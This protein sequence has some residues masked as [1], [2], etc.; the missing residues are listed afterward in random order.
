MSIENLVHAGP[1]NVLS[2]VEKNLR[3]DHVIEN[4]KRQRLD[5]GLSKSWPEEDMR[6][7]LRADVK[8]SAQRPELANLEKWLNLI[9]FHDSK[10]Q[11]PS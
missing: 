7:R 1:S 4:N 2:C 5:I 8:M 3:Q 6:L 9:I 10:A 11:Y